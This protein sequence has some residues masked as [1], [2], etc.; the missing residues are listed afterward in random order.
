MYLHFP[1]SYFPSF[2]LYIQRQFL[3]TDPYYNFLL[4]AMSSVMKVMKVMKVISSL[5]LDWWLSHQLYSDDYCAVGANIYTIVAYQ[6]SGISSIL[7][8]DC[9]C[10]RCPHT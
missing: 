10:Q 9:L 3:L 5:S 6:I 2:H 1:P 7:S 8:N 4:L